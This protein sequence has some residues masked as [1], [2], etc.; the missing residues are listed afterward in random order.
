[1]ITLSVDLCNPISQKNYDDIV[2]S[3]PYY[4][5]KCTCGLSGSLIGH[6]SYF[7]SIKT[8][9]A[10]ITLKIQRVRCSCDKTHALLLSTMVPHAQIPLPD[11]H[12]IIECSN[13]D[14]I[15]AFLEQNPIID[16]NNAKS[17]RRRHRLHWEQRL[18]A[19][20]IPLSPV[21]TLVEACFSSY[22]RAFMQIKAT[23]N[24]LFT[25]PT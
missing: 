13:D 15:R 4:K 7:R 11:Q 18:L 9:D 5:L 25:K 24:I 6:G 23:P 16:E 10:K 2:F 20:R 22:H 8:G 21:V 17:I 1:M 14:E 12:A 19:E 3:I